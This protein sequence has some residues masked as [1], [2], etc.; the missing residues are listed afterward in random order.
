MQ[1]TTKDILKKDR[2]CIKFL[3]PKD[4]VSKGWFS[5][6]TPYFW[7][8]T[9]QICQYPGPGSTCV[10]LNMIQHLKCLTI[11]PKD[12]SYSIMLE[13]SFRIYSVQI[14]GKCICETHLPFAPPIAK[15]Y[16]VVYD[17]DWRLKDCL[18]GHW[19]FC[20]ILR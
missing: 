14:S 8:L 1:T 17:T 15:I 18:Q 2:L 13:E 5:N 16:T 20:E 3:A 10:K 6:W 11:N 19:L 9:F 12:K 4:G 7:C